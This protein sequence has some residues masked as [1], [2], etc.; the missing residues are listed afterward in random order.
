MMA[1][2]RVYDSRGKAS[3]YAC[4]GC[5]GDAQEWAY[6]HRDPDEVY[7]PDYYGRKVTYSLKP[8]HY[9]PMCIPCH[10]DYDV[11]GRRQLVIK[12]KT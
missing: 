3:Q 9:Q 11:E 8:E 10:A 5:G 12:R 1:H 7:D 2:R 6:D 4:V